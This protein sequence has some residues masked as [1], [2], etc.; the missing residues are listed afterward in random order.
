MNDNRYAT[1][2]SMVGRTFVRIDAGDD[3]IVFVEDNGARWTFFHEQDCCEDVRVDDVSGAWDDL[4]GA[5]L[6]RAEESVSGA[7]PAED[8]RA[9]SEGSETWTYYKFGT[10]K[11][12]VDVRWYGTSNGYYSESVSLHRTDK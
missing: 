9:C 10:V 11:G 1:I 4:C 7:P 6:L 12:D 8:T 2:E 5:P 3:A